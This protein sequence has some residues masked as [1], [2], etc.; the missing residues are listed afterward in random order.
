M[1]S[2]KNMVCNY[3]CAYKD[4]Q[5][6]KVD[7]DKNRHILRVCRRCGKEEIKISATDMDRDICNTSPNGLHKLEPHG[8]YRVLEWNH[9]Y[10]V[11][12]QMMLCS[13]CGIRKVVE[14]ASYH[15][16]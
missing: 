16:K 10:K 13:C 12:A 9:K 15:I 3:G 4:T 7:E 5:L 1:D 6:T 8:R 11:V 2:L 14:H